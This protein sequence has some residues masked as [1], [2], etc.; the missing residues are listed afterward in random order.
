MACIAR[1]KLKNQQLSDA[2]SQPVE[3][4][5]NMASEATESATLEVFS[6]EI[7]YNFSDDW[8]KVLDKD[9]TRV[10]A[11]FL[12]H[13]LVTHFQLK[14]TEA[15]EM[16]AAMIH[17]SDRSV[18]QWRIDLI[19]NNRVIP[20]Q[21]MISIVE[22]EFNDQLSNFKKAVKYVRL[23]ASV[24]DVPNMTAL[25]F[26]KWVNKSLFPILLWNED[27]QERYQLR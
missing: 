7:L 27:F 18:R 22:Q 24:K 23:H 4:S 6:A 14:N 10:L 8:V 25:D 5:S 20:D 1:E 17:K 13:N 11:I 16:A 2:M 9:D 15:A 26:F 19:A 21:N 12:C 3:L